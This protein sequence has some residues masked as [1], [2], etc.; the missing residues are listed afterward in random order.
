MKKLIFTAA[1]IFLFL[2]VSFGQSLQKGNIIRIS[3]ATIDL[4]PG[5]TMEQWMEFLINRT[6]P[7]I[8]KNYEGWK[9]YPLEKMIGEHENNI[10]VIY[11]IESEEYFY[12]YIN[13]DGSIT[14]AGQAAEKK[15]QSLMKER[16][17]KLGTLTLK[18]TYW[19]IQ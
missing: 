6:I 7:E 9:L 16:N 1:L 17:E 19:L 15:L 3:I 8:E 10:S 13:E 18:N 11:V 12:K 4:K 5:V 2:G 14:E